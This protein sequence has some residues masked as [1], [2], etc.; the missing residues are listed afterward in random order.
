MEIGQARHVYLAGPVTGQ[1]YEGCS[2]WREYA[3]HALKRSAGVQ[4]WSPIRAKPWLEAERDIRQSYDD[5]A[6]STGKAITE[7]D[8]Y[9]C[10][11]ADCVLANVLGA[12]RVSLGTVMEIAWADA[13]RVPV[14]LV[15]EKSGNPHEH[16]MLLECCAVVVYNLESGI[17][18][19]RAFVCA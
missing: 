16:A 6:I 12:T 1:S 4:V 19:V 17:E 18:A 11:H 3:A 9:D 15:M 2:S 8:R 14:V 10:T 7:R 5:F 13:A